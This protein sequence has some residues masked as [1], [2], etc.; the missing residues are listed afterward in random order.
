LKSTSLNSP[1]HYRAAD[2]LDWQP[3][4][5]SALV[6][7]VATILFFNLNVPLGK[8]DKF[9]YLYSPIV[10][11]RLL[12]LPWAFLVAALLGGGAWLAFSQRRWSSRA[13]LILM[14]AGCLAGSAWAYFAPPQF[15]HQH[16]FNMYSP[17][18]DGAFLTE[19][20][21]VHRV[22]VRNYLD[23]FPTRTE[24]PAEQMR[25]TR[26][27]SNPPGTTLVAVATLSLLERSPWLTRAA[28]RLGTHEELPPKYAYMVTISTAFACA[29]LLLW[30][31]AGPFLYWSARVF[32]PPASAAV[33]TAICLFSPATLLFTPGKDPAQ[34]LTVALPLWL[35]LLA[36][37]REW[38]WAAVLAGGAFVFACLVSLVHVWLAAVVFVATILATPAEQRRRLAWRAWLPALG[39]AAVVVGGLAWFA[40]LNLAATVWSVARA[41]AEVTRGEN[42]MPLMWQ[43]LGVPL[44]L[45]FAGPAL[46][47]TAWWSSRPHLRDAE[48]RFG[49]YLMLGAAVVMLA[50]VGFTN[51]ETPRLWIPFTPLLLLGGALRLSVFRQ[52]GRTAGV[53]LA[54]LVFAQFATSAAQ[55][56][57]MDAREAEIR[58]LE[59]PEGGARFFH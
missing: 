33:F 36:W 10:P 44:F 15:R 13:G 58:L 23:D 51:I 2:R 25:G 7:L 48:A 12:A 43:T 38:A 24:T 34:L 39:G 47:S 29:L 59:Q 50:T 11:Q 30:L 20:R 14:A 46:W 35:W 1:E 31:L 28:Y 32:F 42:A 16:F 22:G 41:Q 17:S 27:T 21:Y 5:L 54:A 19:A 26:V 9:V 3:L 52:P 56:S 37:R 45:L 18:Q 8:P 57:L 6:P 40:N 55:W 49:L 53:L 4:A